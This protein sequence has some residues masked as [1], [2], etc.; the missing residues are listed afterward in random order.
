[1]SCLCQNLSI[2]TRPLLRGAILQTNDQ[3]LYEHSLRGNLPRT[4]KADDD[5]MCLPNTLQTNTIVET[6]NSLRPTWSTFSNGSTWMRAAGTITCSFLQRYLLI[7][8]PQNRGIIP[9]GKDMITMWDKAMDEIEKR[10]TPRT[11][12]TSRQF[13]LPST[14]S[15][16]HSPF[17]I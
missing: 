16:Q 14:D 9:Q 2:C 3:S 12:S 7:E 8:Q 4:N 17:S 1:M 5:C 11:K 6:R 10:A 13:L 15:L